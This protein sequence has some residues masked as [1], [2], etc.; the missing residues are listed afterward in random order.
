MV[1]TPSAPDPELPRGDRDLPEIR[2]GRTQVGS[3]FGVALRS[4]YGRTQ[5]GNAFGAM[6]SKKR[7]K[8]TKPR[9]SLERSKQIETSCS[10]DVGERGSAQ[11]RNRKTS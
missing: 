5:R 2:K 3:A 10:A 9:P 4:G 1:V 8:G 11:N 7:L 6:A